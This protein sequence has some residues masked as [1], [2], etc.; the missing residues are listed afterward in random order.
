[1]KKCCFHHVFDALLVL[2]T[3]TLGGRAWKV[4]K[5]DRY[6]PASHCVQAVCPPMMLTYLP[7]AHTMQEEA[8]A[9]GWYLH[10]RELVRVGEA[11][12]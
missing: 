4:A 11:A 5:H 8:T 1:M 12:V 2:M 9:F 7:A 3:S 6:F 10:M